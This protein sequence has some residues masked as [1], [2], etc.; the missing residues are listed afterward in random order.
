[1]KLGR[2]Y[3]LAIEV[4]GGQKTE[5]TLPLTLDF[6][7]RRNSQSSANTANFRIYNLH[8]RTRNLIYF[9]RYNISEF[10]AIQLRAGYQT[11]TP[12]IF[13]GTVR[14]A[15]SYREGVNMITDIECYDGG[16]QM[17]NGFTSQTI[18]IGTAATEVIRSLASTLPGLTSQP[19]VGAFNTINKRGEVLFGNT[20]EL[21]SQKTG[22]LA[23]IDNG[24]VKALQ[25]NE[26]ITGEI[27]E[28]NSDSGLLG[29]PK[30]SDALLEFDM[31]FEPR[32]TIGQVV[33]LKSST[34]RIFNGRYKVMGVIHRGTISDAVAGNATTTVSLW[35]GTAVLE[36]I[37]G[38]AIP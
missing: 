8:E 3:T 28:I 18:G 34:N 7:V 25:N 31:L 17:V 16:F 33:D 15:Y 24:Q 5:V 23:N 1:M 32:L 35:L 19:I 21:I 20:W 14:Q 2:K 38:T 22:G 10:R 29:S 11:F 6:E 4:A 12:L 30:R 26:V 37:K 9:D 36:V 27:V 13:N